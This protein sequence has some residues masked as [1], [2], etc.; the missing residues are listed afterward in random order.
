MVL[1]VATV[2]ENVAVDGSVVWVSW[3]AIPFSSH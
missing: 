3:T 2:R 1:A